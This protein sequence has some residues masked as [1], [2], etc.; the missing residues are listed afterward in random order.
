M[1]LW[2]SRA[3]YGVDSELS[4]LRDWSLPRIESGKAKVGLQPFVGNFSADYEAPYA[5]KLTRPTTAPDLSARIR[6]GNPYV[7]PF[8]VFATL[9][10][11]NYRSFRSVRFD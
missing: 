4:Q 8:P 7:A 9:K 5:G 11:H 1:P 2:L 6:G 10:G 3:M